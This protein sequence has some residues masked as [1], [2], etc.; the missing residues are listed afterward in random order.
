MKATSIQIGKKYEVAVGRGTTVVKVIGINPKTGAHVC[1]TQG[2]KEMTIGDASRFIKAVKDGKDAK[3]GKG[4]PKPEAAPKAA[5]TPS[6]RAQTARPKAALDEP[7]ADPE[8]VAQL[9]DA[10]K[11]AERRLR[12]ANNAFKIGLV[13]KGKLD[14]TI[15][16][17]DDA[18]AALKAAGGKAGSGGRCL[19][20]MSGLEAAYKVLSE[21]G[22]AMTA[23]Q[24]CEMAL[25][26]GYWEPQGSTPEATISSA[27]IIEMRKKGDDSRFERVGRGLFAVKK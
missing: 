17:Y 11:E 7:V 18:L 5:T 23:R 6:G 13:S 9:R 19:G 26:M 22:E 14:D 24:I 27:M 25:N 8:T 16:E 21:T 20:Q 3:K 4:G 15:A 10:L 1:E 2:G 12:I